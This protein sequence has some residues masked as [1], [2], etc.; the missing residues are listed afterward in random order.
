MTSHRYPRNIVISD[1]ARAGVGALLTLGPL[2]TVPVA[3]LA[4]TVLGLLAALFVFFAG[5]TWVRSRTVV[6]LSDE[7]LAVTALRH[8]MIPWREIAEL[9]LRYFATKRDRSQGWMQLTL[10]CANATLRVESSLEGF[11]AVTRAAA[12]AAAQ[13]GL[14]LSPSTVDNL[15]ALDLPTDHLRERGRAA[16]GVR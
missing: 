5:R 16:D 15:R 1:Y 10:K 7:G 11:E 8:K 3:S 14:S 13:R 4:G 6:Q 2:T 9:K 12:H